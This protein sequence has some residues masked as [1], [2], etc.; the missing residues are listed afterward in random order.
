[1]RG[2]RV[3][4][5]IMVALMVGNNGWGGNLREVLF[6]DGRLED[7]HQTSRNVM[8][9]LFGPPPP[10]RERAIMYNMRYLGL[11]DGAT[12]GGPPVVQPRCEMWT[13]PRRGIFPFLAVSN[14]Q[15]LWFQSSQTENWPTK[16][17]MFHNPCISNFSDTRICIWRAKEGHSTL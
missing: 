16:A 9:P 5:P 13:P 4:R 14:V 2:A 17:F 1:M 15:S 8:F 10:L 6:A 12:D 11:R 3:P 7:H